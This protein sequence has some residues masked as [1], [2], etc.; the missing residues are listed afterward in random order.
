VHEA[1]RYRKCSNF[2]VAR[3]GFLCHDG[4]YRLWEWDESKTAFVPLALESKMKAARWRPERPRGKKLREDHPSHKAFPSRLMAT[5]AEDRLKLP[6][7]LIS[8]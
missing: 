1:N 2:F 3:F 6:V 8:A 7:S 4:S 5:A